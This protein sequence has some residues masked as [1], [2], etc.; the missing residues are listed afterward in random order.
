MPTALT[1]IALLTGT[2]RANAFGENNVT[3]VTIKCGEGKSFNE[4]L[5][6]LQNDKGDYINPESDIT[7]YTVIVEGKMTDED[8]EQLSTLLHRHTQKLDLTNASFENNKVMEGLA[9]DCDHLYELLLPESDNQRTITIGKNAFYGTYMTD[10]KITKAIGNIEEGA[11]ADAKRL[12][13]V[14]V[15]GGYAPTCDEKAFDNPGVHVDYVRL[16]FEGDAEAGYQSYREQP[17]FK[18]LLTKLFGGTGDDYVCVTQEHADVKFYKDM[19]PGWNTVIFPI[20]NVTYETVKQMFG[21]NVTVARFKD[22]YY[23]HGNTILRFETVTSIQPCTPYAVK[24]TDEGDVN[25]PLEGPWTAED[26][27]VYGYTK[28]AKKVVTVTNPDTGKEEQ[29]AQWDEENSKKDERLTMNPVSYGDYTFTANEEYKDIKDVYSYVNPDIENPQYDVLYF[30]DDNKLYSRTN[31]DHKTGVR[32]FTAFFTKKKTTPTQAAYSVSYDGEGTT[33]IN[34]VENAAEGA[35]N[36]KN[37]YNPNGQLVRT[38]GTTEGLAKG[39]YIVR[40]KKLMV[41]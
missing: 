19:Y 7:A 27:T 22:F 9:E 26:V 24:I 17:G 39:I 38:D 2:V 4:Q 23:N 10:L 25:T 16:V 12:E 20:G 29:Q 18:Y 33:G 14:T 8:Q 32:A 37:V 41:R 6:T 21:D 36:A 15:E 5:A 34:T 35:Y 28:L 40:G 1:A 13:T 31:H 3:S 11:F 30:G